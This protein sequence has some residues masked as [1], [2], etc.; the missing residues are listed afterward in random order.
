M[1]NKGKEEL[2]F[3]GLEFVRSDWTRFAKKIQYEL[4]DRIFHDQEV[5][6]WIKKIVADL[7]N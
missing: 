7:R 6:E 1:N 4:F 3:T 5:M 2:I